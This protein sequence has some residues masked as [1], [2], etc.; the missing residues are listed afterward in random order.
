M[1]R[2]A[3]ACPQ[4]AGHWA[5]NLSRAFSPRSRGSALWRAWAGASPSPYPSPCRPV[6]S[7]HGCAREQVG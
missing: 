4:L 3:A 2:A 5:L 1:R 7:A 6:P